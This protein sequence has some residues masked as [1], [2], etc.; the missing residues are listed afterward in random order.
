M[1]KRSIPTG[2]TRGT[3]YRAAAWER[4][5]DAEVLNEAERV[6]GAIY[7]AGYA[8]ESH[9]KYAVCEHSGKPHLESSLEIHSWERLAAE[10]GV[11]H[12]I[13]RNHRIQ[14]IYEE[15]AEA[16]NTSLRYNPDSRVTSGDL[17]LYAKLVALYQFLKETIP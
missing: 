9:L 2:G 7:L 16:W 12:T 15:L 5:L 6:H 17:E 10:S 14:A 4:I 13:R 8:I 3:V 1:P 11:V